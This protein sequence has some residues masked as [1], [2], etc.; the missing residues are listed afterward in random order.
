VQYP[1]L[2][3][4]SLRWPLQKDRVYVDQPLLALVVQGGPDEQAARSHPAAA[5]AA[6]SELLSCEVDPRASQPACLQFNPSLPENVNAIRLKVK[7]V[8]ALVAKS[9]ESFSLIRVVFHNS[10][11]ELT[12]VEGLKALQR[13]E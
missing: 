5:D 9:A 12:A 1:D 11:M 10:L 13:S 8:K 6:V 4:N 3:V 7:E 2:L